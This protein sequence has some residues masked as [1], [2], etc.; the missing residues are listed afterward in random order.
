[1]LLKRAHLGACPPRSEFFDVN[2]DAERAALIY[3]H[4][5]MISLVSQF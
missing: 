3:R 1:M 4:P 2:L 5:E